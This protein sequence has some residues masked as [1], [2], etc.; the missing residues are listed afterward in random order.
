MDA[1]QLS[2]YFE[3]VALGVY[4]LTCIL[5]LR[6]VLRAIK[7]SGQGISFAGLPVIVLASA[8]GFIVVAITNFTLSLVLIVDSAYA[9]TSDAV[10]R[11]P[12]SP[13]VLQVSIPLMVSLSLPVC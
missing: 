8:F 3:S 11:A 7:T 1:R 6:V 4:M 5:C 12:S 2:I 13:Q 9:T 10:L